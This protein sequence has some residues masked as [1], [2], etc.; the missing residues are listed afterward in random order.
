MNDHVIIGPW[1]PITSEGFI[2]AGFYVRKH[3]PFGAGHGREGHEHYIDHVTFIKSGTVRIDWKV[4]EKTGSLLV[5]APNFVLVPANA[6]HRLTAETDGAE[7][8][9]IFAEHELE[10]R[11]LRI[12]VRELMAALSAVRL[13]IP[14]MPAAD[15][16]GRA[17]GA[18]NQA[19]DAT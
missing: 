3:G 9:C 1:D 11:Q 5:D 19:V 7:W 2:G 13:P 17:F 12:H 6:H 4:G 16:N 18:F 10:V 14:P 15:E 8:C